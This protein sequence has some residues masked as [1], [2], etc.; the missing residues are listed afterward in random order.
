M[1]RTLILNPG[2]ITAD[3]NDIGGKAR[4]LLHIQRAGLPVPPW[5]VLPY[6]TTAGRAW[7]CNE[8]L[9][10]ELHALVLE[11][12]GNIAVRSSSA[13]EDGAEQSH[14]GQYHTAFATTP[15]ELFAALDAVS[16][17]ADG[18]PMAIVLQQALDPAY[19]GVAF[20][21]DPAGARP[22]TLYLEAV[23]GHGKHLVDGN[24]TPLRFH[25]ALNGDFISGDDID[26]L[27][28]LTPQLANAILVL[29]QRLNTAVDIEWAVVGESLFLLQARPL[30]A[31]QA[32]PALRP[33]ECHTS[34]FFDQRF[35]R[36]IS[37]FTRD[38][39]VPLIV[40]DSL[41]SALAMRG[42]NAVEA[43]AIFYGGQAYVPHRVYQ[44]MLAGAPRWWLSP[45]LRQLF[46]R[47]CACARPLPR[48][49]VFSYAWH[50]LRAVISNRRA[51]FFNV[52]VWLE[53]RDALKGRIDTACDA[54]ALSD[55]WQQLDALSE[56]FLSIHRWSILWADYFFRLYTAIARIIGDDRAE[57][58][59]LSGMRLATTEA[60]DARAGGH[61]VASGY[62]DRSDSLDYAAP[63]WRERYPDHA[64][65]P[66]ALVAPGA[67]RNLMQRF[68]EMREEQ[69]LNWEQILARQRAL[70]LAHAAT[71]PLAH[72]EDVW[73]LTW[74]EFTGSPPPNSV[75][76]ARRHALHIDAL[77]PKPLFVGPDTPPPNTAPDSSFQGIGASAGRVQGTIFHLRDPAKGL[78]DRLPRPCILVV[79]AL[80]PGH[81]ALLRAVDG[82]VAER[83]GLLSH[84]A[85]LA[86]ES[87]I[88]MVTALESAFSLLPNGATAYLDGQT[89]RVRVQSQKNPL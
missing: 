73:L 8:D 59:L 70:A 46:P 29:E 24:A 14:A 6:D 41:G 47:T 32:D 33:R 60:N 40:R 16:D 17:S 3:A 30:T 44:D 72:L 88:P 58:W 76:A 43:A 20:S 63:T 45:D 21:A 11:F 61:A 71:L 18:A 10:A 69:R 27:A 54:P 12:G 25:I 89:G 37:P 85:I 51:V 55:Q 52:R 13:S 19:A 87:K 26:P 53:F 65:P 84:A 57:R 28:R 36:P 77:I 22:D 64:T 74:N 39:L 4:G 81:T 7:R 80:D 34:W 23:A 86:R 49:N 66:P 78:P 82:I 75:L 67:P 5:R 38:T 68:L 50:A 48:G 2:E 1:G 56:E 9:C 79:P 31:L 35:L 83:G 42:R 62:G 15:D